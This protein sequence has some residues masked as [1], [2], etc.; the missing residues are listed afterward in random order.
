MIPQKLPAAAENIRLEIKA[1]IPELSN[2]TVESRAELL[3]TE[4][5]GNKTYG[6]DLLAAQ[7]S[8]FSRQ[9]P[10]PDPENW[11]WRLLYF[12]VP[13]TVTARKR[14]FLIPLSEKTLREGM[15][16][17]SQERE[18]QEGFYIETAT[19]TE[20]EVNSETAAI[21]FVSKS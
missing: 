6:G 5:N 14:G 20:T 21:Y 17:A 3:R 1:M 15:L 7:I 4:N 13:T 2:Q 16:A 11:G 18:S 8:L 9:L 12:A 10:I 19:G